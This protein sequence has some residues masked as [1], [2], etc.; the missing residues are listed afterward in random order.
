MSINGENIVGQVDVK[1][2]IRY[3]KIQ[4]FLISHLDKGE[5]GVY[6]IF[7]NLGSD[8]EE[9]TEKIARVLKLLND[10]FPN[11]ESLECMAILAVREDSEIRL[12]FSAISEREVKR[13]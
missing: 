8:T 11:S 5:L 9:K 4:D 3:G 2:R 13:L 12:D 6:A 10:L 7:G 1:D